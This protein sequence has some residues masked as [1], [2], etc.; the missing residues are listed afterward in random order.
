MAET[1]LGSVS[2]TFFCCNMDRM[3]GPTDDRCSGS[4]KPPS[5]SPATTSALDNVCESSVQ[6]LGSAT[7]VDN[8][9]PLPK[10]LGSML[11]RL[12]RGSREVAAR[13]L[14]SVIEDVVA[15]NDHASWCRL[16]HFSSRCFKV[17]E[18]MVFGISCKQSDTFGG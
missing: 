5:A 16:L 14:T 6:G 11:K 10:K 9:L 15:A 1:S 8:A 7:V 4:G 3:H 18:T 13:K 2:G 12:P 17:R